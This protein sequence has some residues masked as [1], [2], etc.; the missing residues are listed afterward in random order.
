MIDKEGRLSLNR[1]HDFAVNVATLDQLMRL[2][3]VFQ[4]EDGF[5]VRFELTSL[6][7]WRHRR[8]LL[9]G[10]MHQGQ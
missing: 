6:E 10:G 7:Q 2:R 4:R 1:Q 9:P 3:H 8:H 5:Q